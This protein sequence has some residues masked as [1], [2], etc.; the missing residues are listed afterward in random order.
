MEMNYWLYMSPR[1][2][3]LTATQPPNK[4]VKMLHFKV[5]VRVLV[6]KIIYLSI[7]SGDLSSLW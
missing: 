1:I 2:N 6:S 3:I 4:G 5:D 7:L